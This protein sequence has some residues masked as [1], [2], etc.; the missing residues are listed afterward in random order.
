MNYMATIGDTL[1]DSELPLMWVEAGCV[2]EGQADKILQGRDYEGGI[3]I[4]KITWQA[5]WKMVLPQFLEYLKENHADLQ[6]DITTLAKDLAS[7][8]LVTR[9]DTKQF[10][11]ILDSF[12][13]EKKVDKNFKFI[14]NYM[15]MVQKLL[16]LTRGQRTED[17]TLYMNTFIRMLDDFTR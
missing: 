15:D 2:S 12:L 17:F 5:I 1:Q 14:W 10:S 6:T 9:L 8:P 4:H 16:S 7:P 3:R 11:N 13:E